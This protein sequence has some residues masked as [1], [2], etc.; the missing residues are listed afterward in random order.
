MDQ[1]A[2]PDFDKRGRI[3]ARVSEAF[4]SR[5]F[6]LVQYGRATVEQYTRGGYTTGDVDLGFVGSAPSIEV[7]AEVMQSLGCE[8]GTRLYLLDGVMVDLGGPAELLGRNLTEVDTPEGKLLLESPEE[9]LVQ[10]VLMSVYPQDDEDQ[11]RAAMLLLTQALSGNLPIDWD[12]VNRI[13]EL[14]GF[15]VLPL[16]ASY[17]EEAERS[18]S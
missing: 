16:V 4:K 17:K 2:K 5:G 10:R 13:A 7:R 11:R 9:S 18:I 12:E 8:R 6:R 15:K 14:P 1:P 3:A